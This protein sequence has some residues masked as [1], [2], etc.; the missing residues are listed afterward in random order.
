MPKDHL[1]CDQC[2]GIKLLLPSPKVLHLAFFNW[3]LVKKMNCYSEWNITEDWLPKVSQVFATEFSLQGDVLNIFELTNSNH[4]SWIFFEWDWW[5]PNLGT[6]KS[7]F[8]WKCWKIQL[9]AVSD[10]LLQ[11]RFLY[12]VSSKSNN[13]RT[14]REWRIR[15][16]RIQE[17]FSSSIG[18]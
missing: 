15:I 13:L 11:G 10:L 5:N 3:R 8:C 17:C 2:S 14:E 9:K 12:V 4:I 16:S 18:S 1:S 7:T 6:R